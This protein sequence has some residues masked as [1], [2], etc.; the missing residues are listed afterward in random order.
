[1]SVCVT[2][3]SG[4]H[5]GLRDAAA[6]GCRRGTAAQRVDCHNARRCRPLLACLL[7]DARAE[8]RT[9]VCPAPGCAGLAKLRAGAPPS[10][11]ER[12]LFAELRDNIVSVAALVPPRLLLPQEQPPMQ[13][14]MA[15]SRAMGARLTAQRARRAGLTPPLSRRPQVCFRC[16]ATLRRPS[17][18]PCRL[19][20]HKM[21]A[22]ASSG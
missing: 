10:E 22:V 17:L 5:G 12:A 9:R 7:S 21:A 16:H 1:M 6:A 3:F 8:G 20:Q 4:A 18:R 11:A 19:L 13:T 14:F 2:A 15:T